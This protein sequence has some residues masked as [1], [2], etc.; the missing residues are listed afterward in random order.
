MTPDEKYLDLLK[1][2]LQ[3]SGRNDQDEYLQELIEA[4]KEEIKGYGVKYTDSSDYTSVLVSYASFLFRS[5][6][7][8]NYDRTMPRHLDRRIKQM[9]WKQVRDD[10]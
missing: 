3:R 9:I 4:A 2:D 1:S 6:A 7:E 5:R 10:E 8:M